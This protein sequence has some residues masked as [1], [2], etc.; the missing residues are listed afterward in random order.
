MLMQLILM[1]VKKLQL[2]FNAEILIKR[3]QRLFE[4]GIIDLQ[5]RNIFNFITRHDKCF[6]EFKV[7]DFRV[8][9]TESR[10][11]GLNKFPSK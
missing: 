4:E 3:H 6:Q 5:V 1:R 11:V 7:E 8:T 9:V 2:A 10:P